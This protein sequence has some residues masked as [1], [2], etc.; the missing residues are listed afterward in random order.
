MAAAPDCGA[1][2]GFE[3]KAQLAL[4]GPKLHSSTREPEYRAFG[5][6]TTSN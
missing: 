6:A 3:M 1:S 5:S 4:A 2:G